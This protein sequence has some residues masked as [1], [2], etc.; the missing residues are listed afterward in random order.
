LWPGLGAPPPGSAALMLLAGAAWG[1]YSLRGQAGGDALAGTAGNFLRA[2]PM[3]AGLSLAT[4]SSAQLEPVGVVSAVLSGAL[5]SGL[6]Y[7]AWYAV[8]PWMAAA[9]AA[10][11]QLSVPV[12]AAAGGVA[13]LGEPVGP[14]LVW[15]SLAVLGGIGLV[16]LARMPRR[17]AG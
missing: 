12:L 11:L 17:T 15:S 9:R 14:R 8:L 13:W 16:I 4:L 7:A 5:A 1:V 6:G 10:A 3:A 2:L